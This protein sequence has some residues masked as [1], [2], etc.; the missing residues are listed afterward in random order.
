LK[1]KSILVISAGVSSI[2]III[3][4]NIASCGLPPGSS[5]LHSEES[6]ASIAA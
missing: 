4:T 6:S 1:V 3:H 5:V 2:S